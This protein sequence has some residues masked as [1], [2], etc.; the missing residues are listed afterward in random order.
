M[1]DTKPKIL[2]VDDVR[3]N[4]LA[5]QK[6]LKNIS[7]ELFFANSGDE[8]LRLALRHD[9]AVI[10]LDVQMPEMDGYETA[11]LLLNEMQT[12]AIPIIFVTAVFKEKIYQ[13]KAY[14]MGGVDYIEKPIDDAVLIAKVQVFI[15]LWNQR[16]QVEIN[17]QL[18]R[19][20]IEQ[21]KLIET[22]LKQYQ[23]HLEDLVVNRTS[24]LLYAKNEA[25]R[26]NYAKSGFL[27]NM[28]HEF[29]TPLHGILSFAKLGELRIETSSKEKL[30]GY[31]QRITQSGDRLLLL[32]NN[33]LDLSKL[34]SGRMEFNLEYCNLLE[35]IESCLSEQEQNLK[36]KNLSVN[37]Q[38]DE[39]SRDAV[40]FADTVRIA[41]VL[42]NLIS[43]AIKFSTEGKMITISFTRLA[44]ETEE[45]SMTDSVILSICNEGEEIK[46]H[47]RNKI[48]DKFIQGGEDN[49]C[50]EGTGM[51][52]AIC[53]EIINR[54]H[55]HVWLE[56][57]KPGFT[58]FSFQLPVV[59][60]AQLSTTKYKNMEIR[61]H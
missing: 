58:T 54:H 24:E 19:R 28:S 29:R 4:L 36:A 59:N 41:Q 47:E 61:P 15:E 38:I 40:V 11:N 18:I 48:F 57:E 55:G 44:M 27:A 6:I 35:I 33:L 17:N 60:I 16:K 14:K 46:E 56:P 8:A 42:T 12:S 32:V 51:G 50:N 13:L 25:E 45:S 3:N 23:Q 30:L 31:F 22:E 9:F 20:E 49:V 5:M 2:L 37:W 39:N 21:R 53:K 43:N 26:A 10:L 1:L 52:L 34:E 7:A